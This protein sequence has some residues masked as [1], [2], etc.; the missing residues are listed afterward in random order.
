M[1]ELLNGVHLPLPTVLS[2]HFILASP[3]DVLAQLDLVRAQARSDQH[4]IEH[5]HGRVD[6]VM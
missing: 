3:P 5:V 6:D 2:S 1:L 4:L